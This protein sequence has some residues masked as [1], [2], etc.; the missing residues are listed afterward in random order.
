VLD[1]FHAGTAIGNSVSLTIRNESV[2]PRDQEGRKAMEDHT[3]STNTKVEK[4][5]DLYKLVLRTTDQVGQTKERIELPLATTGEVQHAQVRSTATKTCFCITYKNVLQTRKLYFFLLMH[6]CTCRD[7]T[8]RR[9]L[10][11]TSRK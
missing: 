2:P 3:R 5:N 8:N 11:L 7:L 4:A 9:Y 1:A 6:S 10:C